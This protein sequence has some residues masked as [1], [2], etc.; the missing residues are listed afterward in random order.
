ML[1]RLQEYLAATKGYETNRYRLSDEQTAVVT[2]SDGARTMDRGYGYDIAPE[3]K[4]AESEV[5]ESKTGP[6]EQSAS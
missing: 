6:I 1:P 5:A 4:P 2:Q 3:R